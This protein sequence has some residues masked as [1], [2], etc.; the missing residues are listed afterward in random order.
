MI[1]S[2]WSM[3]SMASVSHLNSTLL[4]VKDLASFTL[5]AWMTTLIFAMPKH[6]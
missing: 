4:N 5:N 1:D 3:H 6:M 2:S